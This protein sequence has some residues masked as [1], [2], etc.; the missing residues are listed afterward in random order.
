MI[1]RQKSRNQFLFLVRKLKHDCSCCSKKVD[2]TFW[3]SLT[4]K[5][6]GTQYHHKLI[7]YSMCHVPRVLAVSIKVEQG[8]IRVSNKKLLVITGAL[9]ATTVT[10]Q[11]TSFH[12]RWYMF[13]LHWIIQSS[14]RI[15][16][17][18]FVNI[19]PSLIIILPVITRAFIARTVTQISI[20]C[21]HRWYL[22]LLHWMIQSLI[23]LICPRFINSNPAL[24][25]TQRM[26]C[27][28][29]Q[30]LVGLHLIRK[31]PY[32]RRPPSMEVAIFMDAWLIC[33]SWH[34]HNNNSM[35]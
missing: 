9:T 17:H 16:C 3:W 13:L 20:S 11:E 7:L 4:N 34:L 35:P 12:Y 27:K 23:H 15:S 2:L 31:I 1:L 25:R 6:T 5:I 19:N 33:L 29:L 26:S 22:C 8:K 14:I 10:Q 28:L 21:H 32:H 18:R 30:Y 24:H